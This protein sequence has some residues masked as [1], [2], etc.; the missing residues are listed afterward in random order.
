[1]L[2]ELYSVFNLSMLMTLCFALAILICLN[3]YILKLVIWRLFVANV[4]FI[5]VGLKYFL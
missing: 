3:L 2:V 1:M 4:I 5:F